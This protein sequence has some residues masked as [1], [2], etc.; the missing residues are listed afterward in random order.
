M[1]SRG[2]QHA[3]LRDEPGRLSKSFPETR[4][5]LGTWRREAAAVVGI[6]PAGGCGWF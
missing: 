5:F 4:A 2:T 6:R 1:I 3:N